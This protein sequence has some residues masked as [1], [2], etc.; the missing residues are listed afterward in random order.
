M[1][2]SRELVLAALGDHKPKSLREVVE[3]TGLSQGAAC[4]VLASC[5]RK[6]IVLRTK[7]AI[8]EFE[9]RFK[10]RAG[11][12][13]TTRPYHLYLLRP[14]GRDQL[15]LGGHEFVMYAKKHLDVRGGGKLSKAQRV[16][17]F[18]KEVA[19]GCPG[20]SCANLRSCSTCKGSLGKYAGAK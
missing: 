3:T 15:S 17:N 2:R 5:W 6:G 8:Y 10:G 14:D 7:D 1:A 13:Q 20:R 11:I 19:P 18:V 16:L 9:R 12:S 4:N